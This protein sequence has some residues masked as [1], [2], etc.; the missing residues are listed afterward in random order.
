[1]RIESADLTEVVPAEYRA[2]LI[3]LLVDGKPVL[4][5]VV[6]VQLSRDGACQ[7]FCVT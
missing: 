6:E 5:I 3:V 1:M 4:A 2:D 7:N